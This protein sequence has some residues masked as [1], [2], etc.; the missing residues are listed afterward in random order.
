MNLPPSRTETTPVLAAPWVV[1]L[2]RL[3]ERELGYDPPAHRMLRDIAPLV[4]TE[5]AR[6][7]LDDPSSLVEEL[8]AG[9]EREAWRRLVD[10]T[11]IGET[12]FFRHPAQFEALVSV[13]RR[14][15]AAAR[16]PL[17]VWSAGCATGEEAW[18]LALGLRE[19]GVEAEITAS[20]VSDAA[21]ARAAAGGPYS[22]RSVGHLPERLRERGLRLER[23]GRWWVETAA[24]PRPRFLAH[25]LIR[26]PAL[27][28]PQGA[29]DLV[30]CR[31]VLLY[32]SP[33]AGREV[34]RRLGATLAEAGRL[35]IAPADQV[36]LAG[37]AL[38][39]GREG[40]QR[41]I[42]KEAGTA[43]SAR[44]GPRAAARGRAWKQ[45][46]HAFV[47]RGLPL[48]AQEV[49]ERRLASHPDDGV[50]WVA[51]A[52][53]ALARHD[54]P[55]ARRALARARRARPRPEG[56]AYFEGILRLKEGRLAEAL[57]AFLEAV[58]DDP[59]DW[60]SSWQAAELYRRQG[61]TLMEEV[62]VRRTEALLAA[63]R[64]AVPSF[65]PAAG[66]VNSA[67][68]EPAQVKRRVHE[69]LA[70]WAAA[71]RPADEEG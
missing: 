60:A 38:V 19:V 36:D 70:Q 18:S 13:A 53:L 26:D 2:G 43:P 14:Q 65:G 23:P 40:G 66:L 11:T 58:G 67:H 63:D 71:L 17:R 4:A 39:W 7:G 20:D 69:R 37:T 68:R 41:V 46:V 30:L 44:A 50:A 54:F 64:P 6:R 62:M 34:V 29:W 15:H 1:R 31:N 10:R 9:R 56:V 59:D 28:P 55:A 57:D 61:R 3:L 22:D 32:F 12:H 24:G 33:A 27:C 25:N 16:R 49:V 45:E 8:A 21:L 51:G 42:G 47:L 5:A 35:W 52:A 48:G